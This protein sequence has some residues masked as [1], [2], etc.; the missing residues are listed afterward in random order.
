MNITFD[1]ETLKDLSEK[2]HTSVIVTDYVKRVDVYKGS[3]DEG[4][5]DMLRFYSDSGWFEGYVWTKREV[6]LKNGWTR[7]ITE[8]KNDDG[9][10]C[11][12]ITVVLKGK[13]EKK[14]KQVGGW[15]M[16]FIGM[17]AGFFPLDKVL[18]FLGIGALM[19]HYGSEKNK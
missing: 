14:P 17:F 15:K 11:F 18:E 2:Y 8:A 4:C 16:F 12:N 9:E 10:E 6:K 19:K 7:L 13:V 5:F 3:L 1:E